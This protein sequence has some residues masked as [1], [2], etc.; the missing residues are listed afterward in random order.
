MIPEYGHF[1]LILAFCLSLVLAVVPML[2]AALRRPLWMACA[3]SL[4]VGQLVFVIISFGCLAAAFL[5]DDFSVRYVAQNS[6][7]LLPDHYKFSAVWGAHE[8]S[9][10]LW[11]LVLAGWT[12]AVAVFSRDL[13]PELVARVLA[14]MGMIAVGFHLF[15]LLT[16]NPFD[17]LVPAAEWKAIVSRMGAAF[18]EQRFEDGLTQALEEVSALLVA[19]FPLDEGQANP[20]E[21]PDAPHLR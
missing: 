16:S 6:D 15:L 2:G 18:R 19:H 17:R 8:G 1:A 7:R 14:V 20:N 4:A 10:L 13:P 11:M 9:L 12:A 5:G 21:L 3:R